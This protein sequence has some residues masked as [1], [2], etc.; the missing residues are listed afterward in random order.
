MGSRSDTRAS[1]DVRFWVPPDLQGLEAQRASYT[2]QSFAPHAHDTFSLVCMDAGAEALRFHGNTVLAPAGR[3]VAVAPGDMHSGGAADPDVGWAYRI[4]YLDPRLL[5]DAAAEVGGTGNTPPDFASLLIDDPELTRQFSRVFAAVTAPEA[6]RL[7]RESL[8]LELLVKLVQRHSAGHR[9]E[10]KQAACT[11]GVRRARELIE[12]S[13]TRNVS[14]EE[15]A[16]AARLSPWHLV[17]AFRTQLGQTPQVYLRT[18]RVRHAQR[19]LASAMP[20]SEVA[21]ASGFADPSHLVKQFTRTIGVTPGEYRA[22][23]RARR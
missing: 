4:L 5:A 2:R 9:R 21:L 7:E 14:L 18:L 15:L 20:M 12:A 1:E 8:L 3:L 22:A 10:R 16:R 23:V 13:V 6:A 17:R 19:L 11:P